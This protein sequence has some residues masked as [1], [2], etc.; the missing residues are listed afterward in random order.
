MEWSYVGP[1]VYRDGAA[2]VVVASEREDNPGA[3]V[4]NA[5]EHMAT[6]V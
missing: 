1:C 5:F 6:E 4:T 3:S 2:A